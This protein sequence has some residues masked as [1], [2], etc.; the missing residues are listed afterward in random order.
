M[1]KLTHELLQMVRLVGLMEKDQ[2]CCGDVTVPQCVVLQELLH[3]ERKVTD[4]AAFAGVSPSAMTRLLDGLVRKKWVDRVQAEGDRRKVM[5]RLTPTGKTR[6]EH[7]RELTE[8]GVGVVLSHIPEEKRES[9]VESIALLHKA[10]G[11]ALEQGF[12]CC[13]NRGEH[14]EK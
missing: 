3:G 9:V 14:V 2:V 5:I 1:R 10:V 7:L 4:L 13:G 8:N 12:S 11:L 6:A